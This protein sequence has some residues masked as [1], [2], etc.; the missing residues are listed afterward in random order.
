MTPDVLDPRTFVFTGDCVEVLKTFAPNSIDAVVC[1]PPYG[2]EFMGKEWDRIGAFGTDGSGTISKPGIG[3][4]QTAWPSNRGWNDKRCAKCGHLTHGGSPC[5]RPEPDVR[6]DNSRWVA[7]QAWHLAWAKEALR[8]LKP[9]GHLVAFGGSRTYHRLASAL[10]DA[11]FEIRDSLMWLYGTGFPKSRNIGKDVDRVTGAVREVIGVQRAPGMARANVE[12]GAQR[13]KV[14]EFAKLGGPA[15][16]LAKQW[17]GWG[18]ALKPAHEPIVLARKPL[19]GTVAANVLKWGT[20]A[21]N[22]DRTRIAT[23]DKYNRAPASALAGYSG[24]MSGY[25]KG[26]GRMTDSSTQGRWPANVVLDE[27]AGAALDVQSASSGGASR[28]F[29]SAKTS[30]RERD[31]GTEHLIAF[32]QDEGREEDAPGAN[33]PRNRGGEQRRNH[34]PTVKPVALM[35]WLVRL[36]TPPGGWV[37]DPFLGSGTT[38]MACKRLGFGFVGVER[39]PEYVA[40]AKARISAAAAL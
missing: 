4:R 21:L 14:Y 19:E 8:V 27:E 24:E 30:R 9:G 39:E 7:M 3:E 5:Q 15:S 23:T 36:V 1:D 16:D 12:Q 13:R 40:I 10:E 26:S 6:V 22:I 37:L 29:Y 2:L 33:N 35:E 11:G 32:K 28:F 34:H 31:L 18:T 25:V 17:G 38:G 20:G